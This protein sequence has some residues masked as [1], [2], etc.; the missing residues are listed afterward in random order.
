MNGHGEKLSHK[1]EQTIAA[2]LTADTIAAAAAQGGIA[3]STLRRWLKEPTF[4]AEYRA[5]RRAVVQLAVCAIQRA[6]CTAVE[7]LRHVMQD[8]DAPASAR[9][10]AARTVIEMALRGVE[11]EDM[12]IRIAQLEA[13]LTT[14]EAQRGTA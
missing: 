9:V 7:T 8:R 11:L 2:L 6:T 5:A 10:S 3:E 1:Q 4:Q 14:A 12:E 13:R